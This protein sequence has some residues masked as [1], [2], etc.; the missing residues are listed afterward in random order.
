MCGW[1]EK[2]VTVGI[3]AKKVLSKWLMNNSS[4]LWLT[5]TGRGGTC[6]VTSLTGTS[7]PNINN[8]GLKAFQKSCHTSMECDCWWIGHSLD[9]R[10]A[11]SQGTSAFRRPSPWISKIICW[12]WHFSPHLHM[13]S[14]WLREEATPRLC[15]SEVA[16][17]LQSPFCW[18]RAER[19]YVGE[20]LSSTQT[21]HRTFHKLPWL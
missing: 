11:A 8:L 10:D 16:G 20:H 18:A 1:E 6:Q 2:Y 14:L 7:K 3:W 21:F 12:A 13:Q 17:L 9:K 4:E 5:R 19:V 15:I